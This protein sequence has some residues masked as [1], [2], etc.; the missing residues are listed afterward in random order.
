MG[1]Q[2]SKAASGGEETDGEGRKRRREDEDTP[3][4]SPTTTA[5]KGRQRHPKKKARPAAI[6]RTF[7]VCLA[8]DDVR[9]FTI[10]LGLWSE[11]EELLRSQYP[12]AFDHAEGWVVAI[13]YEDESGDLCILSS[14]PEWDALCH[15]PLLGRIVR[16]FINH[17]MPRVIAG[18]HTIKAEKMEEADDETAAESGRVK[19][20]DESESPRYGARAEE[21]ESEKTVYSSDQQ[22]HLL[23]PREELAGLAGFS[24]DLCDLAPS[25]PVGLDDEDAWP[26]E[27]SVYGSMMVFDASGWTTTTTATA[28]VVESEESEREQDDRDQHDGA[29]DE[30][31]NYYERLRWQRE[32]AEGRTQASEVT[33]VPTI[34]VEQVGGD[35]GDMSEGRQEEV[36]V[37]TDEREQG[38]E[39]A[40]FPS[41]PLQVDAS[42]FPAARKKNG[43]RRLRRSSSK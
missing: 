2:S 19:Y 14:Q 31:G 3:H 22:E 28:S 17:E 9:R 4:K 30:D 24:A 1:G 41:S 27:D 37:T 21:N 34:V 6:Q 5:K 18:L 20:E 43:R 35:D 23:L 13:R 42:A 26:T 10:P 8:P 16:V 15:N 39:E 32:E 33:S 11:F 7:K 40:F 29:Y 12:W 38:G 36:Q 25:A